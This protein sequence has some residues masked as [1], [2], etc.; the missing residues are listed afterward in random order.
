MRRAV[1]TIFLL[2]CFYAS[3]QETF[4]NQYFSE[5]N[6]FISG[7]AELSDCFVSAGVDR[8]ANN[9]DRGVLTFVN[10]SGDLS[11]R[12]LIDNHASVCFTSIVSLNDFIYVVG[13][14]RE[15]GENNQKY[16]WKF[17]K[18]GALIWEKSFGEPNILLHDNESPKMSLTQNGILVVSSAFDAS[19][20]TQ[21]SVTKFDLE[22][23][24]LWEKRFTHEQN[25]LYND[26]FVN[27]APSKDGTLLIMK[28][29]YDPTPL[30]IDPE[31]VKENV[32]KI[33]FNGS[34]IWRKQTTNISFGT[35]DIP[36]TKN[37]LA[38]ISST[39][40]NEVIATFCSEN[41]F[42][43]SEQLIMAYFDQNGE[44]LN[45]VSTLANRD[46]DIYNLAMNQD[47]ELFIFGLD[48]TDFGTNTQLELLVAKLNKVGELAWEKTFG[49]QNSS[50]LWSGGIITKDG[51]ILTGGS[52]FRWTQPFGYD[53]FLVK[54]N[55]KGNIDT[56]QGCPLDSN[57]N[58]TIYPNP[59]SSIFIIEIP[60]NELLDIELIDLAG[61]RVAYYSQ[62]STYDGF[63]LS[64]LGL[65]SGQYQVLV[66][67]QERTW[68]MRV[69][70]I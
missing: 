52:K 54:T 64:V 24:I 7:S 21:A 61:R 3:S 4:F 51:G 1:A 45:A 57:L 42:G 31:M 40:E 43:K 6:I 48:N 49:Y 66:N 13:L 69:M 26:V 32:I 36:G 68:R 60:T 30:I 67:G 5:T 18:H 16:L 19:F 11:Y 65:L 8:T 70:K 63:E 12:I 25:V 56:D 28:S 55:C 10:K 15:V 2:I 38:G 46:I 29:Y 9:P 27:C 23:H 53:H 14:V 17:D 35:M 34:E 62:V 37:V 41:E 33:G 58:L 44:L 47:D 22:G 20:G 39:S 50:D 59:T